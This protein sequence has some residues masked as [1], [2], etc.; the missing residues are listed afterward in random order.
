[1]ADERQKNTRSEPRP[2]KPDLQGGEA[3][4]EHESKVSGMRHAP[5]DR[6]RKRQ[7]AAERDPSPGLSDEKR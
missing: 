3:G 6:E 7:E 4:S 2:G 5:E 1:M